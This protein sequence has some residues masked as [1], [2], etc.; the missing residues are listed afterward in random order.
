MLSRRYPFD[1]PD[2]RALAAKHQWCSEYEGEADLPVNSFH[3]GVYV[4]GSCT[5]RDPH[6]RFLELTVYL[7]FFDEIFFLGI[8]KV[9]ILADQIMKLR[10]SQ[11]FAHCE[12][13]RGREYLAVSTCH[14]AP[15][16][17]STAFLCNIAL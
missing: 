15:P 8:S 6:A 14:N 2:C 9:C 3:H 1:P 5:V 13:L 17:S 11:S 4:L 10:K 7:Q 16:F 12:C